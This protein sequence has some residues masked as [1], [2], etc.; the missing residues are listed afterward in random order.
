[1]PLLT[2]AQAIDDP[3][4]LGAG[5]AGAS[6]NRWKAVLKAAFGEPLDV[7]ERALFH[8]VAERDPPTRR[9][10]E[11]WVIAGRR[12][13]KDSVAAAIAT[14]AAIGDY[15]G[16]LRPG[17]RA[18]VMCLACDREQARI[19]K[20][21]IGANFSSTPLLQP[22]I[23]RETADGLEL[24]NGTEIVIGTNDF[25]SVRGRSIICAVLDEAAF[26]RDESSAAPDFETYN[27]ILPGLA[28]LP[29][30]MLVGIS[31]PYRRS[32]LLFERW[33]THYGKADDD[34]LVIRAPSIVLNPTLSQAMIDAAIE[35]D[36]DAAAAEWMAEFRSDLADFVSRE[37]VEACVAS[38]VHEI[39]PAS[40]VT[41][42]AFVDPSGGSS[43]SMTLTI[44]HRS[45]DGI[46]VLDCVRERRA[47]FSPESV[48]EEFAAVLASYRIS[49]VRGDR[50]AGEW[51]RERFQVHGIAYEPSELAK[52]EIYI[53]F[54]PM[55]NSGRCQLLD[56]PR[57]VAQLTSLERRTA[58]GGR[59]SIDHPPG[60]H[61]DVA[62]A[63]A[64]VLMGLGGGGFGGWISFW[65][66]NAEAA[67]P[68]LQRLGL[69]RSESAER[70]QQ[71][72]PA[73][74][75]PEVEAQ[76][77]QHPRAPPAPPPPPPAP[78]QQ[79]AAPLAFGDTSWR[80][81]LPDVT[82][83]GGMVKLVAPAPWVCFFVGA[84]NGGGRRFTADEHGI[85]VVPVDFYGSLVR[86]GCQPTRS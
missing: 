75:K 56:N 2:P 57:L 24:N 6:W 32:G 84:P 77:A 80:A 51:P 11:L 29:D 27:A 55:L 47:P 86:A 40:D 60:A 58:R 62:N 66:A 16:H 19:V 36:P 14:T 44:G 76:P 13:G 8:E 30:A 37:V 15:R 5:F 38:G 9:V 72:E 4:L 50:Y 46:A 45:A 48:V 12:A 3:H 53:G 70:P 69:R 64:G 79:P 42:S 17:E 74:K 52:N 21:Y 26:W 23:S 28:T 68:V 71:A 22:M 78:P 54:L 20:R 49:T 67:R 39:P 43:D 85:V 1:M 83:T 10:R 41:Y 82:V 25:R 81:A 59:D 33:R 18:V 63:V 61:D 73:A 65:K 31:S 35:R 34:V 7:A